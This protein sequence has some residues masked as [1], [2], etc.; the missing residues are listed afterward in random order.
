MIKVLPVIAITLSLIAGPALATQQQQSS[1]SAA[2]AGAAAVATGGTSAA[3]TGAVRSFSEGGMSSGSLH[4]DNSS[5]DSWAVSPVFPSLTP[6]DCTN[7]VSVLWNGV[8]VS[9]QDDNCRYIEALNVLPAI[10]AQS[11]FHRDWFAQ[12]IRR[13]DGD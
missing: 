4:N 7:T 6:A 9:L 11:A 8:Y 5:G 12:I 10:D 1:N 13:I 3:T 2:L